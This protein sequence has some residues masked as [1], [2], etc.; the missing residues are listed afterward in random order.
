MTIKP[1]K[2]QRYIYLRVYY[3]DEEICTRNFYKKAPKINKKKIEA[4]VLTEEY[5]TRKK[6]IYS[7][8][9]STFL[10]EFLYIEFLVFI[11]VFFLV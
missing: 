9:L 3:E 5:A 7:N 2:D 1:N 11:L 4:K 6:K 8:L 10:I